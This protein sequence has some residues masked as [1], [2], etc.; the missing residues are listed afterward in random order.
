MNIIFHI[1]GVIAII[2]VLTYP[3]TK[4]HHTNVNGRKALSITFP[5]TIVYMLWLIF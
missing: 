1:V 2:N 5:I 4:G 3:A